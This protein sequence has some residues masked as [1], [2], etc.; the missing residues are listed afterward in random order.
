MAEQC[1][2]HESTGEY[3]LTNAATMVIELR[4]VCNTT[5]ATTGFGYPGNFAGEIYSRVTIFK[6][7]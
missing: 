1:A 3:V 6:L 4:H 5:V 2:I 7:A